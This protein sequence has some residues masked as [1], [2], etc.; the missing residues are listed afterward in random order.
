MSQFDTTAPFYAAYRPGIP[1]KAVELLA[2][3]VADKEHRVLLDLGSGTGQVPLALAGE[4]TEIDVVEQDAGMLDQADK[5]LAGLPVAVRLHNTSAEEFTPPDSYRADLVTVCRAFHWMEQDV[6]LSRLEGM[7]TP[8][9]T[10]AVMGDGSL[11]TARTEWTDALRALIQEYLG[12][13]RRAGVGRKYAAH[14]RPYSEILAESAFSRVEEHT[15]AVERKWSTET[16]IG[17]LYSTSF[18]ARPL[19]GERV[20]DFERRARALLDE[21]ATADGLV[22]HASFQV[23]LGRRG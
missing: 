21:H 3:R 6:V 7:T 18:A 12:E 22:E 2:R 4:V 9:A 11:W 15:I 20:E 13:E 23:V 10:V 14:D 1:K 19:F 17:Y 8:E 5:A 16:V